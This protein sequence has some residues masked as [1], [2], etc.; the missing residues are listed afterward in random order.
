MSNK[1]IEFE[2][3]LKTYCPDDIIKLLNNSSISYTQ[4]YKPVTMA[5][6]STEY[7][8][9]LIINIQTDQLS[10]LGSLFGSLLTLPKLSKIMIKIGKKWK[11]IHDQNTKEIVGEIGESQD[12]DKE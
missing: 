11:K 9:N 3:E 4:I 1:N 5:F 6:D 8:I 12:T 2:L 7:T 10:F